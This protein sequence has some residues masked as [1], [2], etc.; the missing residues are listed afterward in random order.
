MVNL[1][2]QILEE[3]KNRNP[4]VLAKLFT[5]VNPYLYKILGSRRIYNEHAYD[6]LQETWQ[7][8]LENLDKF[9]GRSQ[10]KTFLAGIL[11]NKIRESQRFQKKMIPEEDHEKIIGQSFTPDGWWKQ[12]PDSPEKLLQSN[13]TM[14]FIQECME[15]LTENQREA[16]FMKEVDQ[17]QTENICKILEVSSTH[18]GVLLFRAKQKLR[19][20]VEGKLSAS[21]E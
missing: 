2:P 3:L 9:E 10:V 1:S 16:F 18:L 7:T 5:E 17:D 21:G 14:S 6:L 15:S 13:Q 11:I 12:D 4:I 19:Q 8:F 20:C